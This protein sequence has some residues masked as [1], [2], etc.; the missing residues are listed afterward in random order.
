MRMEEFKSILKTRKISQRELARMTGMN[1]N[2]LGSKMSCHR[3][4]NVDEARVISDALNLSASV[5]G[6]IF[7]T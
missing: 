7:L 5:R 2:T 4:F 1:R 3:P 6:Y